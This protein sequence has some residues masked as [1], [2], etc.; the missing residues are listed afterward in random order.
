MDLLAVD[1]ANGGLKPRSQY[2]KESK[3][4]V[5]GLLHCD[6]LNSSRLLLNGLSL[7]IVFHQQRNSFVLM[8]DDTSRNCRVRI[9]EAQLCV[10]YVKLSDEKYRKIQQSLPATQSKA[11]V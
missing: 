9:I 5:S 8:A 1:G 11:W 7:K 10:Q 6:L 2:I 3:L 4:V